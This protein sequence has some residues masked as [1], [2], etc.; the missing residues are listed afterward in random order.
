[1]TRHALGHHGAEW[2]GPGQPLRLVPLDQAAD[3]QERLR[4]LRLNS[5]QRREERDR[6]RQRPPSTSSPPPFPPLVTPVASTPASARRHRP[7]WTPPD[8]SPPRPRR[9]WAQQTVSPVSSGGSD[10]GGGSPPGLELPELS[11]Q[12]PDTELWDPEI[13]PDPRRRPGAPG[14]DAPPGTAVVAAVS[15]ASGV[16]SAP[17]A[18]VV[19]AAPGSLAALGTR[20]LAVG[21]PPR[22]WIRR[23][24]YGCSAALSPGPGPGVVVACPPPVSTVATAPPPGPRPDVIGSPPRPWIAGWLPRF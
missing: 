20:G 6:G 8:W 2:L 16:P 14:A 10:D 5:R 24:T 17:G 23:V 11:R 22:P 18:A 7:V 4:R 12:L 15:G 1:M 3:A 13:S 19:A 21:S 9:A